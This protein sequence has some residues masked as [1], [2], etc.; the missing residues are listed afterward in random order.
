MPLERLAREL[1]SSNETWLVSIG[2]V[3]GFL[4][5]SHVRTA[6]VG[7]NPQSRTFQARI[8][9]D[10]EADAEAIGRDLNGDVK[11][12]TVTASGAIPATVIGLASG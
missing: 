5:V 2:P 3:P 12:R 4:P 10:S 11:G 8:E 1:S 9:A 7:L 6:A